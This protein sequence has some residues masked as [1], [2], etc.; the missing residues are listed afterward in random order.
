MARSDS[1]EQLDALCS[2]LD[3]TSFAP[4]AIWL[5]GKA[6]VRFKGRDGI[7]GGGRDRWPDTRRTLLGPMAGDGNEHCEGKWSWREAVVRGSQRAA[8]P[9]F[10]GHAPMST[11]NM[12]L[13]RSEEIET[14]G[15]TDSQGPVRACTPVEWM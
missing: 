1:V 5:V 15:T 7:E 11:T 6:N 14:I 3:S 8:K 9:R 4:V 10:D 12:V 13:E 2:S